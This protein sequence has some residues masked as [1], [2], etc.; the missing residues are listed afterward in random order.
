VGARLLLGEGQ[1][2]EK[3]YPLNFSPQND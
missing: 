1:K 2:E 3:N